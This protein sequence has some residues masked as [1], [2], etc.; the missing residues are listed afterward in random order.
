[1]SMMYVSASWC[2][3][4]V[5]G[6]VF[7]MCVNACEAQSVVDADL[8]W[9][10]AWHGS[11]VGQTLL[12]Q[13]VVVVGVVIIYYQLLCCGLVRTSCEKHQSRGTCDDC[14]CC[15]RL[16][17]NKMRTRGL[18]FSGSGCSRDFRVTGASGSSFDLCD[19]LVH[20]F[21]EIRFWLRIECNAC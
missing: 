21:R 3:L 20:M 19:F 14:A 4:H 12:W 13:I 15:S 7:T 17:L 6:C 5:G 10:L 18:R 8:V 9:P 1:M 11:L 16:L 2:L